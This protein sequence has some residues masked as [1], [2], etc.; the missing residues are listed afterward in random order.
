MNRTNWKEVIKAVKE[1]L[2]SF[3]AAGYKPTLR[4]MFYR[5]YSRGLISNTSTTYDTLGK[6]TVKARWNSIE[7]SFPEF[8][9]LPMDCFAD[10]SRRV[11]GDFDE[12][13]LT[14][15]EL[16]DARIKRLKDTE[17]DYTDLIPR[18]YDQPNYVEVW[19]EKDAMASTFQALLEDMDVRIVSNKGFASMTFLVE[20]AQRLAHYME[21]GKQVH[22]LY[23]GD[24]DPSGDYMVTDLNNRLQR[25]GMDLKLNF[26]D[27][28]RVA[29][30]QKQIKDYDLPYKPDEETEKKMMRDKQTNRF[31]EKY[32]ELYA[33]ELDALPALVPDVFKQQLVIDKVNQYFDNRLYQDL[34][35]KHKPQDIRTL[36]K[37]QIKEFTASL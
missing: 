29:V 7:H 6:E 24:F 4:A 34:L 19:I 17:F 10:K 1:E 12:T 33:V 18:W 20:T 30:T 3:T 31:L 11:I 16:I 28:E 2:Q 32:G 26:S 21:M 5:L 23:Y 22:I 14:P 35:E 25:M 9:E 37:I 15:Q 36:L 8:P 27:F 13:Y